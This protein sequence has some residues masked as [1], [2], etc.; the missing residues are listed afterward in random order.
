[1]GIGL[2]PLPE[3]EKVLWRGDWAEVRPTEKPPGYTV[4]DVGKKGTL[5]LPFSLGIAP[6]VYLEGSKAGDVVLSVENRYAFFA[7]AGRAFLRAS[8]LGDVKEVSEVV[9]VFSPLLRVFGLE[10]LEEAL[11]ELKRLKEDEVRVEGSHVLARREG[12]WTLIFGTFFGSPTLDVRFTYGENLVFSYPQGLEIA[13]RASLQG[14]NVREL[15]MAVRWE[16]ETA[17]YAENWYPGPE[18]AS[19]NLPEILVRKMLKWWLG[20]PLEVPR[21]PRMRALLEELAESDDPL[22][23]PKDPGFFGRVRLRAVAQ[24]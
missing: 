4:L 24:A 8:A 10:S 14:Y 21:S 11:E 1:L 7:Q 12:F 17:R 6:R 22:E 3:V 20:R 18:L 19:R 15:G 2:P 23:A 9:R 5:L 13:L 16:G